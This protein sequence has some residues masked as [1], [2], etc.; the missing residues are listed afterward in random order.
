MTNTIA[1]AHYCEG[2]GHATRMLGVAEQL[3]D[4]GHEV[5]L[6]GGGPGRHFVELNGYSEP[7]MATV[8]FVR[9]F[10]APDVTE[11][12]WH[13]PRASVARLRDFR[14]WIHA[15]EP[16]AIVSDD[17]YATAVASRAS[18]PRLHLSH[19]PPALYRGRIERAGARM[20]AWLPG[21]LGATL[22]HPKVWSGPPTMADAIEVG[23]IAHVG[24]TGDPEVDVLIVPSDFSPAFA[25][26]VEALEAADRKVTVVGD[27]R[28]TPVRSLF[29]HVAA[30]DVVICSGYSTVMEAAVA[31]T[32]CVV[33]P[34]TSEQ[35]G[36]ARAVAD[37]VGFRSATTPSTV[38]AAIAAIEAPAPRENGAI[39]VADLL[40]TRLG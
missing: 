19:D 34:A 4:R 40:D 1:I 10:Q 39:A 15:L 37:E 12:F 33:V 5:A 6:A 35:R 24:P 29:P 23:P 17:L 14:R 32:P 13:T 7:T 31:G 28:W 9:G 36:V 27:A 38:R 22:V 8:D 16:D 26:I 21:R 30:A 20:R 25:D 11:L 3:V 18:Y 2:A